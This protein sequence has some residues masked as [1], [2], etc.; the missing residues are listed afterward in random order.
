MIFDFFRHEINTLRE[1]RNQN[2]EQL[3]VEWITQSISQFRKELIELREIALNSSMTINENCIQKKDLED[4][5]LEMKLLKEGQQTNSLL[6]QELRDEFQQNEDENQ[7]S[8]IR[9]Q[10]QSDN[11]DS[12][13]HGEGNMV[14]FLIESTKS[15]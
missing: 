3:T 12:K 10:T 2:Q 15:N 13:E 11:K 1:G 9:L 14:S 6:V 7:R 5:N 8:F 4:L